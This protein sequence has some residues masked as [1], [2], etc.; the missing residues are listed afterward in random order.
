MS[1]N[2]I[3]VPIR[4]VNISMRWDAQL[5]LSDEDMAALVA[6]LNKGTMY[7]FRHDKDPK[8][9]GW[10]TNTHS[11]DPGGVIRFSVAS[12]VEIAEAKMASVLDN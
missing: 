1:S 3:E 8:L 2:D 7:T 11:E 4:T 6:L 12:S 9:T 5:A 10:G